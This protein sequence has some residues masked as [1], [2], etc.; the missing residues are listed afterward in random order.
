[1]VVEPFFSTVILSAN[2]INKAGSSEQLY[3]DADAVLG[4]FNLAADAVEETLAEGIVAL[5]AEA[6]GVMETLLEKTNEYV[7]TRKQFDRAIG[8]FQVKNSDIPKSNNTNQRGNK[9][10]AIGKRKIVE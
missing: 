9:R 4:Q 7:K 10:E 1:M 6:V 5:S 3:V 2:L 8:S